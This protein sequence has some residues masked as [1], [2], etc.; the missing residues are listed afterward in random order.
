MPGKKKVTIPKI[1]ESNFLEV[2]NKTINEG[3]HVDYLKGVLKDYESYKKVLKEAF[4]DKN[5]VNDVYCFRMIYLK[6]KSVWREFLILG[7]QTFENLAEATIASMGWYNDHMHGFS[8]L[9]DVK[10]TPGD[11]IMWEYAHY[12]FFADGWPDDPYPT[13]KSCQIKICDIDYKK[14]PKLGFIFDFGDTHLFD[15]EL[16]GTSKLTKWLSKKELPLLVDQRGVAPEQY[17]DWEDYE[18]E[19]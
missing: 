10:T 1:E 13:Y 9:V 18:D 11:R 7:S 17:P 12:T 3:R 2:I 8:L 14:Y 16:K 19:E 4:T 6:K 15:V 5:P